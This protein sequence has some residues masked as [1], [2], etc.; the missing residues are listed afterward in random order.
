MVGRARGARR[1]MGLRLKFNLVILPIVAAM[2]ALMVLA[3]YRHEEAAIVA[4][5]AMHGATAGAASATGPVDPNLLP[6]VVA[7]NSLL[8]HVGYAGALLL[9]LGA[10][11]N[12]ALHVLV[13]QPLERIRARL[14]SMEHGHWRGSIESSRRDEM[15]QL[16]HSFQMLGLEIDALAGQL[17]HAERLAV[18]ALMAQR[19]NSALEP[20]LHR[21][22]QIAARVGRLPEQEAR[23]ASAQLANSAGAMLATVRG[24]DRPFTSPSP[25][26]VSR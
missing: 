12:A 11:V 15:G 21:V 9:L 8:A 17:L 24:L 20:E 18:V 2:T 22:A 25:S 26:G 6:E 3:D 14:V 23:D 13:L 5:H 10:V 1:S 4:S 19:L 7:R 16:V